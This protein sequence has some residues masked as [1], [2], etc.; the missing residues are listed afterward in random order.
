MERYFLKINILEIK[1]KSKFR[2]SEGKLSAKIFE[3]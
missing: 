1:Y 3:N 2:I